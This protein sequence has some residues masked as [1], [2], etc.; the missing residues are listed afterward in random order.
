MNQTPLDWQG[1]QER[2]LGA[3]AQ[4]RHEG[5]SVLCLPE[6]CVTGYGCE[7]A[8]HSP[9]TVRRAWQSLREIL[10][11]TRGM[12]V[13]FGL[14]LLYRNSLYNCAALVVD[15][16]IAGFVAKRFLAGDGIH[17]EPRWFKPWP[18]GLRNEIE[19]EGQRFPIGDLYF[20]CGGVRIGYEICEDA[21]VANRPGA[22][23][24]LRA[25]DLI[26]NP[27]ASH[28]AFGKLE[29]RK[30]FV[31]EG[32]RA[33]GA[34]Y[35]YANL[36]GNESGRAIYDGGAFIASGGQMIAAGPRFGFRDI[37]VTT[38]VIDLDTTRM[39]QARTV[40]FRPELS[41]DEPNRVEC[42]F[43]FPEPKV[44]APPG[45]VASWE[46]SSHLKEE[47]F[48]RAEALA[49]FDYLRKSRSHGF[50][51][52][53]S[54]GADSAA[55]CCLVHL[56]CAL[57]LKELGVK[58]LRAKLAYL[59]NLPGTAEPKTWTA[60]ILS[61]AYQATENSGPVTRAA[62]RAVAE[63]AG[64]VHYEFDVGL[65][66]RAYLDA[67]EKAA[68]IHL[69]WKDHDVPLQNIQARVRSPGIWLLANVKNAL[70]L[71]TSNRS[72]AAVGYA[73]MDG[74]TSGGLSP[75]AGIDKAWLRHW[76]RWL[77]TQGPAG[78]GPIPA[79]SAVTQ[80]APTAELRPP[81]RKQ[82]DEDDLMPYEI[83]DFIERMA[84]RDKRSP[85]ETF[86]L[87]RAQFPGF[88]VTQLGAWVERF[89]RLWCRNQWKRERDAPSFHL[90]DENLDPKTWCRFP[91]LS[92]GFELELRE[93]RD[94]VAAL[95]Q[96]S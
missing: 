51:V 8:F 67:V 32:S 58:E 56:L 15:G 43:T 78:I 24:A 23:L 60:R 36:L 61:T 82:T 63:A 1:N 31:L 41:A 49:L 2:I 4:A 35:L 47:E 77:E 93:L 94:H 18:Q 12:I 55:V 7:D 68:G 52:S 73:T 71:A 72:E 57:V 46:T 79:L 5:A 9:N 80:Q 81:D 50:V 34:A 74:D 83:L 85:L 92:G 19:I 90:D 28:F 44:S 20:D 86:E 14:P 26:L 59:G 70:L 64:A 87:L 10:P 76:L 37:Y 75:L 69:N 66:K 84:I 3:I 88:T 17:Y 91:I 30:R 42:P 27:S 16:A 62:A 48:T 96:Q 33:F 29:I 25:T 54:G 22:Q 65:I 95:A 89:F 11:A 40:G 13:S 21:W 38:A 45:S 6:L 53:L 39:A